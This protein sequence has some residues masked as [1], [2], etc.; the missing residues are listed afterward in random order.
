MSWPPVQLPPQG[1]D[2]NRRFGTSLLGSVYLIPK[3]I[4]FGHYL[5]VGLQLFFRRLPSLW[6]HVLTQRG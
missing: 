1:H 4:F 6:L 2:G 3:A 5:L